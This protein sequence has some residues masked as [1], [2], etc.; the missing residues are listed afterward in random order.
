MTPKDWIVY[1]DEK[2]E[3]RAVLALGINGYVQKD[4]LESEGSKVI[5]LVSSGSQA[6][7]IAYGDQVLR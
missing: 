2:N 7:A 5:G 1:I 6:D 3:T 4:F